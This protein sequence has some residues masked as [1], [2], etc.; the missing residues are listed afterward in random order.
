M[1]LASGGLAGVALALLAGPLAR[2]LHTAPLRHVL[3]PMALAAV[4][5]SCGFAMVG[6]ARGFGD[7]VG[8]ALVR[9]AAG[10]SLRLAGVTA[11]I[12][13]GAGLAGIAWGFGVGVGAGELGLVVYGWRRGWFRR[14][15]GPLLE[16]GLLRGLRPY[17]LMEV[18]R[19][20]GQWM[21]VVILG[22]LA[23][24]AVVGFYGIARGVTRAMQMVHFSGGHS[25]LPNATALFRSG[26]REAFLR[27]YVRTRV[28]VFAL[29]W[30][31][32]ALCLLTPEVVVG[33]IFGAA[34]LPAAPMLRILAAAL[35]V[36]T[37]WSS[38]KDLALL[39]AGA[40]RAA[41]NVTVLSTAATLAG[42]AVLAPLFGGEGAAGALLA[43]ALLRSLV[44]SAMLARRAR[45]HPLRDDLPPVTVAAVAVPLLAGLVAARAGV[46]A[47]WQ[48]A[49]VGGAAV[50]GSAAAVAA[51][52]R[53]HLRPG[54]WFPAPP[55]P[56]ESLEA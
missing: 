32:L 19:Q 42:L 34:Y 51:L 40:T 55:P 16:G 9:D 2:V 14:H 39:A 30:P 37:V 45:V 15:G 17:T 20:L 1:S 38:F 43:A 22:A 48:A 25:F 36:E 47:P 12:V 8:R 21:D 11:A 5:I 6:V 3:P 44:L 10:G 52:V 4:A 26:D 13:S 7:V 18:L 35:L 27:L 54:S 56:E 41:A 23:S 49:L 33:P 29:V 50:A 31:A 28:L 46:P 53:D 24:P